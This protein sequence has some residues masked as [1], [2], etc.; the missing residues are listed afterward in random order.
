MFNKTTSQISA[1]TID[2]LARKHPW[3]DAIMRNGRV[4]FFMFAVYIILVFA[5]VNYVHSGEEGGWKEIIKSYSPVFFDLLIVF[6]LSSVFLV[7]RGYFIEEN[8]RIDTNSKPN[9]NLFI[10]LNPSSVDLAVDDND[11]FQRHPA[12]SAILD[13][14]PIEQSDYFLAHSGSLDI[15]KLTIKSVA[16]E[17]NGG[18]KL[19]LGFGSFKEFFFTHHFPDYTLSRSSARN[20]GRKETLRDLFSPIYLRAYEPFFSGN[21]SRLDFLSYTPNTLGVTGCVQLVGT[22]HKVILFQ[23]RGYHESAA[24]GVWHLSYAGTIDAYPDFTEGSPSLSF[25]ELANNEFVDE[26]MKS[27]PGVFISEHEKNLSVTHKIVGICANSQ[28]LFQPEIFILT[29][30]KIENEKLLSQVLEKFSMNSKKNFL[31]LDVSKDIDYYLSNDGLRLRPLC[32]VAI[33]KIYK[34]HL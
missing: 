26:F 20:S 5:M 34:A 13:A 8:S 23:Q 24:R 3:F 31:A 4:A 1:R 12:V 28:Y 14:L 33:D 2:Y 19:S 32:R 25:A 7:A 9:E 6:I 18:L 16:L 15:P 17:E 27:D 22:T 30:I 21:A 10:P 11:F 29:T